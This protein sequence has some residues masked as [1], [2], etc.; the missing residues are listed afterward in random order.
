[1]EVITKEE[2]LKEKKSIHSLKT[3]GVYFLLQMN[4]IVYI[5]SSENVY[6][7]IATHKKDKVF[8]SFHVIYT[9]GNLREL[10]A[11]CIFK[12]TPK[13]NKTIPSN[14]RIINVKHISK[15][16]KKK[17]KSLNCKLIG[18]Y[19]YVDINEII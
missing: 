2:I 11:F 9:S 19:V 6:S 17:N 3:E 13:Y 10:E 14:D 4:D 1:M 12:Y 18:P 5:G 16:K 8:D 7:R 15:V